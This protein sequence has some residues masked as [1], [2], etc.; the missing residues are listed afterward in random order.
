MVF[1]LLVFSLNFGVLFFGDYDLIASI[2][3]FSLMLFSFY[4]MDLNSK[5]KK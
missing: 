2:I 5:H 1:F 3:G 4:V